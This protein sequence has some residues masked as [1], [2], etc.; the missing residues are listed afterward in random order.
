MTI[1]FALFLLVAIGYPI[2]LS[3]GAA[4]DGKADAARIYAGESPQ[5]DRYRH[6]RKRT[7]Q[8]ALDVELRRLQNGGEPR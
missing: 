4:K 3:I 2:M 6:G 5:H 1:T 7:Y 8:A